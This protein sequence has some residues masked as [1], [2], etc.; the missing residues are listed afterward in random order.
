MTASSTCIRDVA[1]DNLP[2]STSLM[3]SEVV[4]KL[5]LMDEKLVQKEQSDGFHH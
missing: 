5:L 1:V 3:P 4:R 2:R